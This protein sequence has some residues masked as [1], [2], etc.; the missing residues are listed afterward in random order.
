VVGV[1]DNNQVFLLDQYAAKIPFADQL[2]KIQEYYLRFQPEIIGIESNAY[3]AALVQQT[4]RLPSMPP[5]VPIF[6]KGKKYERIMAMSPLFRIGKVRIRQEHRD[7]IDEWINY[8]ASV[9]NPKDDCL[10]SVE[11]ALRTAGALLGDSWVANER[12]DNPNNL[13]EWVL[14]DRPSGRREDSFVDEM[15]GSMW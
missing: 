2:E 13:P 15:M 12:D 3:Q 10:D 5:V 9:R 1:A 11:I 7:F 8:D 14:A 4:E 6:A